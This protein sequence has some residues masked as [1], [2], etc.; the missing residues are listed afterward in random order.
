MFETLRIQP[1]DTSITLSLTTP[2]ET[3]KLSSNQQ[4]VSRNICLASRK[5]LEET[6]SQ[7]KRQRN[8]TLA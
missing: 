4:W 6:L 7:V 8:T 3:I 2:Q 1:A 5:A